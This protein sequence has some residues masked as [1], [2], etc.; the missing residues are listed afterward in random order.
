MQRLVNL[1]FFWISCLITTLAI[2]AASNYAFFP[3]PQPASMQFQIRKAEL[4]RGIE[5]GWMRK[6]TTLAEVRFDLTA[7]FTPMFHWNA[8]QIYLYVVLEYSTP[9]NQR[10]EMIIWDKIIQSP[11]I[12]GYGDGGRFSTRNARNKYP[13]ADINDA[14]NGV[15]GRVSVRWNIVPNV[16]R[17]AFASKGQ[18]NQAFP[19]AFA[20]GPKQ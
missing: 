7:D 15:T 12:T 9:Q 11:A 6:P 2:I 20:K 4:S 14:L 5:D 13:I 3:N 10:N 16:G 19:V 8:K 1:G 18:H 17:L